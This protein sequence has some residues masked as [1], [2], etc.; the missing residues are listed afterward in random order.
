MSETIETAPQ[1]TK[2]IQIN[3]AIRD[4]AT[5]TKLVLINIEHDGFVFK[6]IS[7]RKTLQNEK[8]TFDEFKQL[9]TAK[10]IDID[11]F[12]HN[13]FD[14]R[15]VLLIVDKYINAS[16]IAQKEELVNNTT[17][18]KEELLK[19]IEEQDKIIKFHEQNIQSQIDKLNNLLQEKA[20]LDEKISKGASIGD[21]SPAEKKKLRY[22]LSK[23]KDESATWNDLFDLF[24]LVHQLTEK[25]QFTYQNQGIIQSF[26]EKHRLRSMKSYQYET[27]ADIMLQE[28]ENILFKQKQEPVE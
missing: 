22:L 25:I 3:T 19:Q 15:L 18:S 7:A 11:G 9:F 6:P 13:E 24:N 4:I 21:I 20:L 14:T 27:A 5:N 12:D 17:A 26:Y 8:Y 23:H 10:E 16:L 1:E 2:E 28:F